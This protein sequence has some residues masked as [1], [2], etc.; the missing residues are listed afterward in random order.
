MCI[1]SCPLFVDLARNA[2]VVVL[3]SVVAAIF[4]QY[5]MKPFYL[6]GNIK[7]GLPPFKAPSFTLKVGN[8]TQSPTEILA[9]S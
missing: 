9:V 3:A 2:I 6:T 4:L 7:A 1:N 8:Y 5:N